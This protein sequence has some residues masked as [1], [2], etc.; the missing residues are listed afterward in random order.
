MANDPTKQWIEIFDWTKSNGRASAKTVSNIVKNF[1]A[2][3]FLPPAIVG[4]KSSYPKDT[5]IP[6]G[7][8]VT[9]VKEDGPKLFAQFDFPGK[10]EVE[11][12]EPYR[13]F[14]GM[15]EFFKEAVN[16]KLYTTRS[17]GVAVKKDGTEFLE[18]V[19]YLGAQL[20]EIKGM[21]TQQFSQLP[22]EVQSR[23]IEYSSS[24][25]F[26][27]FENDLT[28]KDFSK[29][30]FPAYVKPEL[31]AKLLRAAAAITTYE[32]AANDPND[33]LVE[34][35]RNY[36]DLPAD[37]TVEEIVGVAKKLLAQKEEDEAAAA[38]AAAALLATSVT[39]NQDSKTFDMKEFAQ[40]FGKG[41]GE[42]ITNA[43]KPVNDRLAAIEQKQKEFAEAGGTETPEVPVTT[44]AAPAPESMGLTPEQIAAKVAAAKDTLVNSKNWIPAFDE[45]LMPVMTACANVKMGTGSVLDQLATALSA[46]EGLAEMTELSEIFEYAGIQERVK[47]IKTP[48]EN[49]PNVPTHLPGANQDLMKKTTE[50]MAQHP[51]TSYVEAAG[52]LGLM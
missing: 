46:V 12:P 5:R 3:E 18:H 15:S 30:K 10:I 25:E 8:L 6:V 4:H 32:F 44:G 19:G 42:V 24:V 52:A 45:T 34:T 43:M 51:G 29:V 26:Q 33:V 47:E 11:I 50:Y 48:V 14:V 23:F 21:P 2:Q 22:S 16:K 17:I 40:T 1:N 20:P 27:E 41:I 37:T 35:L 49:G 39:Y 38:G 9:A 36:W 7:A 28:M 13:D 31:Q